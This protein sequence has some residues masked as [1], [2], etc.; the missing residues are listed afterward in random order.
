VK[1]FLA[2]PALQQARL[3]RTGE[4]SSLELVQAHL[5]QIAAVNPVVNAAVEVFGDRAL[6]Q[7]RQAD[8][9]IS[10]NERVGD[11]HGVPFSVK[12]SIEIKNVTCTAGTLGR[13]H[14][15]PAAEDATLVRRLREAGAIPI[16]KTN[17]P[18]LLFSFES[19][20]LIFGQTKN[21][22]NVERTC[23]G[24]SGGEA[25]LIA[26]CGSPMGLGSDA[27]GSVRLPAAFCGVSGIKPTSGRLARTGHFP[28][29][30]GWIESL[31][32]IGPLARS[33]ADLAAMMRALAGPDAR[34]R[35]ASTLPWS[36]PAPRD[37][38]DL[39]IAFYTDNGFAPADE[40]VARVV[41]HA[42]CALDREGVR[43]DEHRPA[44][45]ENA[46]DLEMK[47]LGADGPGSLWQYLE[48]IGSTSVH[49]LLRG[50]LQKLEPYRTD[51]KGLQKYW[52]N[53]D[54]FR[55]E[56]FAF[57]QDYDVVLCPA[58]THA[59]LAHGASIDDANFRGFSH[60][61]AFNVAGWPAA[62]VR[63]GESDDGLPIAVQVAAG[64]WREDRVL[65]VAE[66]LEEKFGGWRPPKLIS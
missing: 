6:E 8:A 10:R 65:A 38:R 17:L 13:R 58:Y 30:G 36:D 32:Q 46:Y 21:P 5:D 47:L 57:L 35:T 24:S 29:A 44:C 18:D 51:V 9:A 25:A 40:D 43:V 62:V 48:E 16:A 20:N 39:R 31:W 55:N 22:Y 64:P 53:W 1:D 54:E 2:L 49:P 26:C 15:T 56:M 7:A 61:M 11:F 4:L 19:D 41:R 27:A 28:P 23:G 37:I 59:A 63:G 34:D 45:L 14:A 52:A 50:W 42:A 60:T 66:W 3:I 33:V 12:D